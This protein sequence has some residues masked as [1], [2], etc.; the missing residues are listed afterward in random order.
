MGW[1]NHQPD[2]NIPSLKLTVRSWKRR[3]VLVSPPFLGAF[4]VSFREGPPTS[5]LPGV[6]QLDPWML[7][8]LGPWE[9]HPEADGLTHWAMGPEVEFLGDFLFGGPD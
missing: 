2:T 4:T 1:F 7:P 6:Y 9:I 8:A 5:K 3:F